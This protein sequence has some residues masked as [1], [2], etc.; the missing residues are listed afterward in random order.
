[1]VLLKLEYVD[2]TLHAGTSSLIGISL[3]T[4][5]TTS[6]DEHDDASTT[7][8]LSQFN[9]TTL[10]VVENKSTE[11]YVIVITA[12]SIVLVLCV[13]VATIAFCIKRR[14]R[15]EIY[16]S[17]VPQQPQIYSDLNTRT[18]DEIT[19]LDMPKNLDEDGYEMPRLA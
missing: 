1:M 10:T 6:K 13:I 19:D 2:K 5:Q 16:T 9:R 17:F 14:C 4:R 8:V 12:V 7:I 3:D 15:Q 18:Y 11:N